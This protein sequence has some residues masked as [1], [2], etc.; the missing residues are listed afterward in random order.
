MRWLGR[1]KRPRSIRRG[2]L[3]PEGDRPCGKRGEHLRPPVERHAGMLGGQQL[4][5][6]WRRDDDGARDMRRL[7]VL[8]DARRGVGPERRGRHGHG[9][10]AHDCALLTGGTVACWGDNSFGELGGGTMTGPQT[11]LGGLACSPTPVTVSGLSGVTAIAA[12][13]G[14]TC[15]V[16]AGGTVDCWGDNSLR[17]ARP[18]DE[19]GTPDVRR[20][21]RVL[22]DTRC[23][24]GP[25]RGERPRSRRGAHL[26]PALERYGRGAGETTRSASSAT[27]RF[28]APSNAE[29]ADPTGEIGASQCS[30]SPVAVSGLSGVV[31]LAA[32][33]W[34]TCA[35]LSAGTVTVSPR[36]SAPHFVL[37][38]IS[39]SVSEMR[40]V[41]T[42]SSRT[43][44]P[45]RTMTTAPTRPA[46]IS[47]APITNGMADASRAPARL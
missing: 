3:R 28:S 10:A 1:G 27:D 39:V 46:S 17:R 2:R 41:T 38:L 4:G 47:A 40:N 22:H 13:G 42:M 19:H 36:P 8:D 29:E 6:A 31:A 25:Q 43:T 33:G 20:G 11:C 30:T 32:A 23:G 21:F 18:R 44:R 15:A 12:G 35:L 5:R 24:A 7:P 26:R 14:Q 37:A 16:L 34:E 45:Q 9:L